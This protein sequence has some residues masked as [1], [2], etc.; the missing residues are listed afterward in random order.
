MRVAFY[1]GLLL[2]AANVLLFAAPLYRHSLDPSSSTGRFEATRNALT[3]F[4]A[5]RH[6]DVLVVGDSR[7]YSGLDP[8]AASAAS[9]G[10]LRFLNAGVPGTTPRVWYYFLNAIDPASK[11][12]RAIVIPVD[13]DSDDDSA[14]G[15]VDGDERQPDLRFIVFTVSP[16][17]IPKLAMSFPGV[18]M[19]MTTAID[20][21]L[22]GPILRQ[23]VQAYYA[24]PEERLAELSEAS[25]T[26]FDPLTWHPRRET[27]RGMRVDFT[28]NTIRYPPSVGADERSAMPVQVLQVPHAS[29]SYAAYRQE[30]I[31]PI[32]ERY[33][34]AGTPVVI[35]R[36]PT[37]PAH[38]HATD[39]FTGTLRALAQAGM[40]YTVAPQPYLA[41]ETPALFADH[42]HLDRAGSLRFSRLLG[43]DVERALSHRAIR[44]PLRTRVETT[45]TNTPPALPW[46]REAVGVGFPLQFQS[47]EFWLFVGLVALVFYLSPRG[48]RRY[49]LLAASYYFYARWNGWYIVF[50]LGLTASD[51]F[52]ALALERA[53]G[54]SRSGLLIAGIA[55]NVAFLGTFKYAN[56]TTGTVS[57]LLGMHQDPWLVSWLVPIGISFHTFQSISYLVDV[58]RGKTPAIRDP[59]DY[60][61]YIAFFPQLLSGPIVRAERFFGELFHWRAP[62][63]SDVAY[64]GWRIAFGLFKKV[65]IAD[66][67]GAIADG[68]FGAVSA[69]PGAPAAWTA[70]FAFSMQIYFDFSAYSDIAIGTARLFGFVFPENFNLPYLATS[71]T[72]FWRRWHMTLSS[73]LRDYLYIPLG[74][75]RD[76]RW[77]TLRNLTITMLLGGLWHGAQW[78]FVA[79]GALQGLFLA[80]E[81][82]TG[83]GRS[84]VTDNAFARGARALAVFVAITLAWVLFRAQSFAQA[85]EV[86]RALFFGGA[87]DSMI[88]GWC[89]VLSFGI[90]GFALVRITLG[91][92]AIRW[93]WSGLPRL[94]QAGAI[95]AVMLGA[96]LLSWPGAYATFIYFKF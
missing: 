67:F 64:A 7:I 47:Y 86:Y 92:R 33:A 81:H 21:L 37:R 60:A 56:F 39:P 34:A 4:R 6:T 10:K 78:T 58:S 27:L 77:A 9:G 57:A 23:D 36:V 22:R 16:A 83:I 1:A 15:S 50:L 24:D 89:A 53:A 66:Q 40:A 19:Q 18:Q 28:H 51:Y 55:A 26:T 71:V 17:Q 75:N 68:Y 12:F 45:A 43:R 49:V 14:I 74:G 5:N 25:T 88:T 2:V 8:A 13:A 30:W 29:P 79:W 69:H 84:Q 54:R 87:G 80:F 65:T 90:L 20:L 73:W 59:W 11:R 93:T 35:V 95:A 62:S 42:D 48:W 46:L 32:A 91:D 3:Q 85:L 96:E 76:G 82:A 52:V 61:L 72:E 63:T 31:Y 94:A 70:M 44:A 38:R 41:L